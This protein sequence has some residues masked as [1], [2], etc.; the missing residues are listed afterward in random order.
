MFATTADTLVHVE[1]NRLRIHRPG[2]LPLSIPMKFLSYRETSVSALSAVGWISAFFL[3]GRKVVIELMLLN[4]STGN[5][6]GQLLTRAARRAGFVK[7][8]ARRL[9]CDTT[10]RHRANAPHWHLAGKSTEAGTR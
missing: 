9:K 5:K 1:S 6:T 7:T 10:S 4:R 8:S 3:S 2:A